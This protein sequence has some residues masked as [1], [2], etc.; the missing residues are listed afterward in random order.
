MLLLNY[1]LTLN[2][3][4]EVYTVRNLS[5]IYLATKALIYFYT[6]LIFDAISIFYHQF[7]R[8]TPSIKD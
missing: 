2:H 8:Y 5:L 6:P 3:L 1:L 4:K 7:S